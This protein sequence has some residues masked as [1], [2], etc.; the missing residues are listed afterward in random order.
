MVFRGKRSKKLCIIAP[1][2]KAKCYELFMTTA[3]SVSK[4]SRETGVNKH[5]I[6]S[7][8]TTE[9]WSEKK[10]SIAT[11]AM[12]NVDQ[13]SQSNLE[14]TVYNHATELEAMKVMAEKLLK[15]A[16][17]SN[18][19]KAILA[20]IKGIKDSHSVS[21]TLLTL[22]ARKPRERIPELP[23]NPITFQF[24]VKPIGKC[25]NVTPEDPPNPLNG[26]TID[27]LPKEA[28][29]IPFKQDEPF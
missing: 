22:Q 16:K 7:W 21:K 11:V 6:Q 4:I 27:D 28:I 12:S 29:S 8:I 24:N 15:F 10:I 23:T 25:I 1:Q 17:D 3:Y 26:S 5:T 13:Q 19:P 2:A 14:R 20:M 18:D 9:K